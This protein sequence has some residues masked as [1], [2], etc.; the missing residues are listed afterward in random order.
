MN[1]GFVLY[2]MG[3]MMNHRN[4]NPETRKMGVASKRYVVARISSAILS[5]VFALGFSVTTHAN[6]SDCLD[7]HE[8]DSL[9]MD[10]NGVEVPVYVDEAVFDNSVHGA[11]DCIDCHVDLDGVEL[12]HDTPLQQVDCLSCHDD[13]EKSF[14]ASIHGQALAKGDPLAPRCQNCHGSHDI[15]PVDD[16][17]SSVAP[18]RIPF[19]CGSCHSEGTEVMEQRDIP[20][21]HILENYSESIHGEGLFKKGLSSSATCISCHTAH[22]ILPHTDPKSSIAQDNVVSTCLQCHSEIERVHRKVING[23]LWE[24]QPETIPV[25][26]E[27]HQP[28][29]AR[30]VF[31]EQGVANQDCLMCHGHK[32]LKASD[33]RSLYVDDDEL[34]HSMHTQVACAQCHTGVTPSHERA[35]DTV[36]D[37][38]DC[39]VCHNDQVELYQASTHGQLFAANDPNAP[40]CTDCHGTHGVL[41]QTD[42]SSPTYPTSVPTLCAKCHREDGQAAVR[43]KGSE[44]DIVNNY[45]QSIHGKGLLESGLSVTA[46][47]TSCHTAHNELPA[48]NPASSVNRENIAATCAKC[49]KGIYEQYSAS[50]HS[51]DKASDED[52]SGLPVCSDCHTAHTIER[53]DLDT[54]KFEI[55]DRCG[56]CHEEITKTYFDTFHGKANK[57]GFD[58]AAKCYNCHGAHKILPP[59]DPNST[60]SHQNIVQTCQQCHPGASRNFAGYL[61]HATHHD[62]HRYPWI[63]WSF[64]AMTALLVGTFTFFGIH[65]LLWLPRSLHAR[66]ERLAHKPAPDEKLYVRFPFLY[67]VLHGFMIIS[68]LT[69]AT[70]GMTLKFSYTPWAVAVSK[71]LG[72]FTV[73]SMLHRVAA[74][75]M[76]GIFVVHLSD[77]ARRRKTEFGSWKEL[78][79]GPNTMLPTLRDLKEFAQTIKWYFHKGP[80][81]HYGRWTYWEKFDYLA[82]FWGIAVIGMSGLILWF[83]EFFSHFLPGWAINVATIIHSDEAL[84]AAGFIFSIHFFNTHFRPEK[85][86]MDKVIFTGRMPLEELKHEKPGEYEELVKSGKLEDRMADP[87]PEH[88]IK[89]ITFF[90]WLALAIGISLIIGIIYAMIFVYK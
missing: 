43:Y 34:D 35:C 36:I 64:W 22:D 79:F 7:C 27:C 44:H 65:T 13:Q 24:K 89:T 18:L 21:D 33:G 57:L 90:A 26:V 20:E 41:G 82:V 14:Q 71:A 29:K 39:A 75:I 78:L 80:R 62:P 19:V 25:C 10:R 4:M 55:M 74:I 2:A 86:P 61:T 87:L 31:Y 63:F 70:T 76:I 6:N 30:K 37:K 38:V 32:D 52:K 56:K 46:M 83:P 77:L 66:R 12:P 59:S 28:H 48:S 45:V 60:L 50:I 53:T 67:R 72:G 16:H 73:T 40:A 5:I 85:F 11:L 51:I 68:F 84:L 23:E 47:C 3:S 49:H 81:P 1:R 88:Q 54:F 58:K 69:L 9:T 17:N 15:L 42:T 8:D